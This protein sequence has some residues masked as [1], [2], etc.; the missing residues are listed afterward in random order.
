MKIF[1]NYKTI[2]K[3]GL[4]L[5][6]EIMRADESAGSFRQALKN[7][8][9]KEYLKNKYRGGFSLEEVERLQSITHCKKVVES[10]KS[11]EVYELYCKYNK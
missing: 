7:D 10:G 4:L 11:Q 1:I 6:K 8:T 3:I 5:K 9:T 2:K